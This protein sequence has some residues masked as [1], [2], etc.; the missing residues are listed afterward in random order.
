MEPGMWTTFLVTLK[1]GCMLVSVPFLPIVDFVFLCME[2]IESGT[3][4][5]LYLNGHKLKIPRAE[6]ISSSLYWLLFRLSLI[7]TVLQYR[8]SCS[9]F[10]FILTP[11]SRSWRHGAFTL[12]STRSLV[13]PQIQLGAKCGLTNFSFE[14]PLTSFTSLVFPVPPTPVQALWLQS[15]SVPIVI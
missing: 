2:A 11:W 10:E 9:Q 6:F 13:A 5:H 8:Y 15:W 3:F 1:A 14:L 12:F 4:G 7:V